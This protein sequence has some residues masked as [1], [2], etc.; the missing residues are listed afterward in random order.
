MHRGHY[1]QRLL[2][3]QIPAPE[4]LITGWER[5]E[6]TTNERQN[7][8]PLQGYSALGNSERRALA[9]GGRFHGEE[10][11]AW[12]ETWGS[13]SG[14]SDHIRCP[15][16]CIWVM[17]QVPPELREFLPPGFIQSSKQTQSPVMY[18]SIITKAVLLSD[19]PNRTTSYR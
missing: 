17:C 10:A 12:A 6:K 5:P 19:D 3:L 18:V 1:K 7:V 4:V 9:Q 15:C 16:L 13:K 2:L 8:L 14:I 11:S